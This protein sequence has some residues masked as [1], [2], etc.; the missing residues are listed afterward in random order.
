VAKIKNIHY[1]MAATI[2]MG[3]FENVRVEYGETV[4]L[5][6]EDDVPAKRNALLKRVERIVEE[7]VVTLRKDAQP[8]RPSKGKK[9]SL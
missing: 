7:Q 1:G 9:S 5:S 3:N 4:E 2:N 6:P 8:D